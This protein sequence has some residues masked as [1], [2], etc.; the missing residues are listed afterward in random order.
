MIKP[1]RTLASPVRAL[2][3]AVF[4]RFK[5]LCRTFG[6]V[7]TDDEIPCVSYA[8]G[9]FEVGGR[10]MRLIIAPAETEIAVLHRKGAA[11]CSTEQ[12]DT[13]TCPPEPA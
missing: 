5:D 12:C 1:I 2:H 3:R 10:R 13:P 6:W 4:D 7:I 9:I 11:T 8:G